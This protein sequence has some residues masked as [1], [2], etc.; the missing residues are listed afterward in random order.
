M[1]ASEDES[2]DVDL[3]VDGSV[4]RAWVRVSVTD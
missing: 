1:V 4:E 3:G 2:V